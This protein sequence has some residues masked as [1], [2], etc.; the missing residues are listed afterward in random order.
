M[1][2]G[3]SV[4]VC[5]SVSIHF[6][7]AILS[8]STVHLLHVHWFP[9]IL[10]VGNIATAKLMSSKGCNWPNS[11]PCAHLKWLQGLLGHLLPS[12]PGLVWPQKVWRWTTR[13]LH[14][15]G[16]LHGLD[17][18]QPQTLT[19]SYIWCRAD[20]YLVKCEVA[21]IQKCICRN[22]NIIIIIIIC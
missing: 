22:I 18:R 3:S 21:Q 1:L 4:P 20:S 15:R 14:Q 10:T 7:W 9:N 16:Q 12:R 13:R 6:L 8:T 17:W 2:P 5:C 11:P 19:T